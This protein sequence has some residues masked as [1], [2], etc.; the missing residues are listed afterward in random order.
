MRA[1][2][3]GFF[4][5]SF[6]TICSFGANGAIIHYKPEENSEKNKKIQSDNLL[7]LDSGG[8]YL[9]MGTTDVTR[10]FYLG[11]KTAISDYHKECFT[12]VLKGHIQLSSRIFPSGTAAHLLDSF[13]RQAL[14][15]GINFN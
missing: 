12:R 1:T 6:E 2:Q 3:L 9:D 4:T 10:T 11:D 5:P 8:H 15:E 14:W 7:L 13:A